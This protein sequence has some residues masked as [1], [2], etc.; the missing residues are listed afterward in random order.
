M[1]GYALGKDIQEIKERLRRIEVAL[2]LDQQG[3]GY[4]GIGIL[5]VDIDANVEVSARLEGDEVV[6]SVKLKIKVKVFGQTVLDATIPLPEVR[7]STSRP[8]VCVGF[9]LEGV[10]GQVC[11][12]IEGTD[13]CA[14]VK[15]TVRGKEF[16]TPK[17]CVA[18]PVA[19][20]AGK[21]QQA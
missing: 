6:V 15:A 7:V 13:V 18:I 3:A 11:A 19:V 4:G 12:K 8:E 2:G 5:A 17:V 20:S 1:E 14:W 21:R 9:D 10:K 16:E